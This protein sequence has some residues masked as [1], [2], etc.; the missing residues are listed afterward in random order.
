M[1]YILRGKPLLNLKIVLK[2][3]NLHMIFIEFK[4]DFEYRLNLLSETSLI[5]NYQNFNKLSLK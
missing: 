2:Q 4:D 5:N 3:K 1:I